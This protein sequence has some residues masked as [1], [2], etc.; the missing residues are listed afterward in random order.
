MT[1]NVVPVPAE[2]R[3]VPHETARLDAITV[4]RA[5][6][7]LGDEGYR[8]NV[9]REGITLTAK[10]EAG[11][12]YGRQTL[13]QLAEADGTVPA[14]EIVDYPRFGHR[15]A[16]L[17]VARHF[18][19]PAEVKRYTDQLAQYKINVLHLHLTDDQGWRLEIRSWPRLTEIGGST[20]VGGGP[21]GFYTQD[22]YRDI[23][24]YAKT[25]HITVI[26][27]I[28]IPGHT[29]AALVAYPELTCD[30]LAPPPFTK[31]GTATG[32]S[33]LC[34]DKEITYRFV[35]D[36]L[37]EV[38]AITPGEYLHIGTDETHA[39]SEEGSR[40]FIDRVLPIVTRLGKKPMGWHEILKAT[41]D[42]V[43]QFWSK[44]APEPLVTDA[45]ANG[46]KVLLSPANR[47]YL[48]MKYTPETPIGFKWAGYLEVRDVYDWDP[49]TYLPEDA[50]HG[51][52]APLWSEHLRSRDDLDFMAFPRIPAIAELAWSPRS[53][54]DW[55]A[56]A[57]R[58]AAHGPRWT[59]QGIEFYRSPQ[60]PWAD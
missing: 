48:D 34:V 27:E 20:Q 33:S 37:G 54:H 53:T 18:F 1:F 30:G 28:D 58:L 16:M 23:V 7:G 31:T 51:I 60:I 43:P 2:I 38:A 17:D 57:H 6:V 39:T 12:F 52:E 21:G 55:D 11:L 5:D 24:A 8:L 35:E 10:T 9:S 19:S 40:A 50:I 42:A 26:P 46:T 41:T 32:F 4:E 22:D 47:V 13:Q 45:A 56:F 15:G 14:C 59:A 25:K 3:P 44:N 36:V 49:G 29:N